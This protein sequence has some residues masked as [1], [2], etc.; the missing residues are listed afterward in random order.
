VVQIAAPYTWAAQHNLPTTFALNYILNVQRELSASTMLEFGYTG[1]ITRRLQGLFDANAPVPSPDGS[2]PSSRAPFP[3]FGVIQTLWG[4]GRGSY[5]ALTAKLQR[6]MASGLTLLASYTLSKSIDNTS[7]IRGQGDAQSPNDSRC[8]RCEKGVSAFNRPNRVVASLVY[9]L[10]FG[11]GKTLGSSWR[12]ILNHAAGGWQVSSIVT[13][14]SGN[15]A[16]AMAPG[17]RSTLAYTLGTR[18]NATG[19]PLKLPK[20]QRSVERWFNPQAF[21]LQ[22]FGT[23]GNAGRNTILGP[24]RK[25]WDFSAQKSFRLREGHALNFRL[26]AFNFANHPAWGSPGNSWGS[27]NPA[28]PGPSYTQIR[29]TAASM[30]QAQLGLKYV[31]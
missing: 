19:Q 27:N 28:Q 18:L 25:F 10:P 5:N 26:E 12:P 22:P 30:R 11:R 3:E 15:P 21:A 6:R 29:A 2:T 17:D 9:E 14:E 23:V 1:S 16:M 7:G 4:D 8:L 31:F 24:G 20:D 13:F